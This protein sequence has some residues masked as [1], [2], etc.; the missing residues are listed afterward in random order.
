M[1]DTPRVLAKETLNPTTPRRRHQISITHTRHTRREDRPHTFTM[2]VTNIYVDRYP[3]GREV[4]FRHLSTC[5][6]GSPGRPCSAHSTVQNAVRMIQYGEAPTQNI[7]NH[8]IYPSS[9][10]LSSTSSGK[11]YSGE[12]HRHSR[13]QSRSDDG[14]IY[15]KRSSLKPTRQHRKE[16]I[17]VVD[18]PPTPTTPPQ[19]FAGTFTAPS[20]PDPKGRP[21]IVDE[22]PLYRP[23]TPRQRSR[24]RTPFGWDSPSTS[25]T[26]FDHRA[27]R[28]QEARIQRRREER[29]AQLDEEAHKARLIAQANEDIKRR[30]A[31][32]LTTPPRQR[33]TYLRPVV[34]QTQALQE[35]FGAMALN[36]HGDGAPAG[37]PVPMV[38]NSMAEE[39]MK[40][41]LRERQLPKRR[42][43]VG[44]GHR[45][46][47][48]LYDDGL[49][50]WE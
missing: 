48:V 35:R 13:S 40:Q 24:S 5:Q 21:I 8:P 29:A 10:P 20:S 23:T 41:R 46:H 4:E 22:R 6:Y 34:D 36:G 28:E 16:R 18:A 37:R 32:P 42:F 26:S 43:T 3:D 50:R 1:T 9:P 7:F 39:A 14:R 25:H 2:C 30:A 38:V 45:R 27:E 49:Y 11:R 19:L 12:S 33:P 31:I 44:P 15:L 47:R 17:I